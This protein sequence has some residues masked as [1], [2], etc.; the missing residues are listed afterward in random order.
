MW[1]ISHFWYTQHVG[2]SISGIQNIV[3]QNI[4]CETSLVHNTIIAKHFRRTK[5]LSQKKSGLQSFSG[6]EFLENEARQVNCSCMQEG[7]VLLTL[8]P[9]TVC[10]GACFLNQEPRLCSRLT[11]FS[12]ILHRVCSDLRVH[13]GPLPRPCSRLT[14]F[15]TGWARILGSVRL[16]HGR[17]RSFRGWVRVRGSFRVFGSGIEAI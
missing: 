6:S 12:A 9:S 1:N 7:V 17:L 3:Y 2:T 16:K 11:L 14:L 10:R 4:C 15:F 8:F 5:H 13:S